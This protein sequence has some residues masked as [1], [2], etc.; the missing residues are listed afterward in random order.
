M[1]GDLWQPHFITLYMIRVSGPKYFSFVN[2]HISSPPY[3]N[4]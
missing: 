4:T 2:L 3:G 1:K